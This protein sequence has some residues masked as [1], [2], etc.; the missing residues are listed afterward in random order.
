MFT[1]ENNKTEKQNITQNILKSLPEWFGLEESNA[2]YVKDVLGMPFIKIEL[3]NQVIGFCAL[4]VENKHHLNMHVLGIKKEYH[5]MGI[6]KKLLEFIDRYVKE[7]HYRYLSVLTLSS[8]N[9]NKEYQQTREFYLANGFIELMELPTLWDEFNPA[10]L[11]I[12]DYM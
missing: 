12:K 3:D 9:P 2:Q 8:K 10:V 4:K 6:G 11:L 5:R 1:F 7:N